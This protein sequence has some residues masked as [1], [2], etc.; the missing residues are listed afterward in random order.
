MRSKILFF[1]ISVQIVVIVVLVVNINNKKKVLGETA[2]N[3]INKEDLIFP[4]SND[5]KYFY[6]LK[7]NSIRHPKADWLTDIQ[8]ETINSDG[9]NER[10]EYDIEKPSDAFR[11]IT[12]GDSFTLGEFVN[13]PDNYPEKLEDLLN[14]NL[15]CSSIKKFE[16][17]NLGV[18]GYDI[19]YA[20]HRFDIRGKKYNPD[21][22]L[23]LLKDDDFYL[24]NEIMKPRA[25]LYRKQMEESGELEKS[26]Q[27]GNYFP[28]WTKTGEEIL[29]EYS[30]KQ[31]F[32]IQIENIASIGQNY[33]NYLIFL[34]FS[35][36]KDNFK[37]VMKDLVTSREKTHF[38]GNLPNLKT[39]GKTFP[40]GHPTA[41]GYSLIANDVFNYLTKN[42]IIPCN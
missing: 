3:V 22:V 38:F 36:T 39:L 16:V 41:D 37:S 14:N 15:K 28:Y 17:I 25:D 29:K 12:L 4:E 19:Q 7:P 2:V 32:N 27:Q 20:V 23:W 9:L 10:F 21:L 30:E 34:T 6:E 8:S 33:D 42:K 5:L 40:D 26:R 11:I 35:Y 13:T 24:I 31:L 1:L 18:G